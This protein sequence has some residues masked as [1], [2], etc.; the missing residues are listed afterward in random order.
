MELA[1]AYQNWLD[2]AEKRGRYNIGLP[3]KKQKT[4]GNVCDSGKNE[5]DVD[6]SEND[7]AL[8]DLFDFY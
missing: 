7:D 6:K 2:M 1:N 5:C 3:V 4:S 8:N